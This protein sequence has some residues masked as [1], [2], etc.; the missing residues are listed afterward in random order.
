MLLVAINTFHKCWGG[1]SN[2][3][4]I[5]NDKRSTVN[6]DLRAVQTIFILLKPCLLAVVKIGYVLTLFNDCLNA[7]LAMAVGL[8]LLGKSLKSLKLV[9]HQGVTYKIYQ[10][11][12]TFCFP[13]NRSLSKGQ[14][15]KSSANDAVH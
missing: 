10:L 9:K 6:I 2:K 13:N 12:L 15:V 7:P 8:G 11:K 4:N 5:N 3:L 14:S 1:P